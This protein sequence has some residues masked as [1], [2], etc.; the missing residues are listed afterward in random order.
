MIL[1]LFIQSKNINLSIYNYDH[2]VSKYLLAKSWPL[3][4]SSI[5]YVLY[6][7]CDQ[8]ML[9]FMVDKSQ[10]GNYSLAVRFSELSYFLPVAFVKSIFPSLVALREDKEKYYKLLQKYMNWMFRISLFIAILML[11]ILMICLF[12]F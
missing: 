4:F 2:I 7:K 6:S 3:A 11:F 8:V 9:G 5:F 1:I 10:V 12:I